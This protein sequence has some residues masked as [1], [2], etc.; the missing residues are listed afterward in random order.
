MLNGINPDGLS[1]W[2]QISGWVLGTA[3]VVLILA[4]GAGVVLAVW[5]KAWF[6]P[7]GMRKGW[8]MVALAAV[9]ATVLGAGTAGTSWGAGLGTS[10]LMP[11]GARPQSVAIEKNAPKQTCNRQA[12]RD[13]D[14]E[15]PKPSRRDREAL[16]KRLA[17]DDVAVAG[18]EMGKDEG[19]S[20]DAIVSL[21]WY[22]QAVSTDGKSD[23]SAANETA[24]ECSEIEVHINRL[25]GDIYTD[26]VVKVKAP[27]ANCSAA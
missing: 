5:G 11:A 20:T 15:D 13:F 2:S 23:C 14:D 24:I 8:T 10:E 18:Y 1:G 16:L 25:S 12:V 27:G 4:V 6:S 3:L 19:V 7:S 21:K 17:G 9:G 26:A 22:A